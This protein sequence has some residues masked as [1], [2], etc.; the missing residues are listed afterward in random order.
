[1]TLKASWSR[2]V[3]PEATRTNNWI[4][5]GTSVVGAVGAAA[6]SRRRGAGRPAAGITTLLALD[7][8]G[9]AY[10]NNTRACARWYERP[11]QGHVDHLWF[12]VF[13]VHPYA[14]AWLDHGIGGRPD[15]ITWATSHYGYLL[16]ST[17]MIRAWWPARRILGPALTIGGL[18]LDRYLGPSRNA[19]WFAAAYYPKLLLGHASAALWSDGSLRSHQASDGIGPLSVR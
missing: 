17:A 9:G 4:T 15:C 12:S 5:L 3:G 2:F 19:P 7:L 13:H 10:V 18:A 8:V 14:V 11:T 16:A 1:M 6:L